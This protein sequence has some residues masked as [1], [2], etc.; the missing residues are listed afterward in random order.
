MIKRAFVMY[1]KVGLDDVIAQV[2]VEYLSVMANIHWLASIVFE[3]ID[4]I[5]LASK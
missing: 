4:K 1:L 2:R 3:K 5:S